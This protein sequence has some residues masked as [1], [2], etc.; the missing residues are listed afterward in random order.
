[1]LGFIDKIPLLQPKI[2]D[3]GYSMLDSGYSMLDSGYSM[4]DSG[5][6]MLDSGYS[7]LDSGYSISYPV[8]SIQ[9]LTAAGKSER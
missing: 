5:Y 2:L 3:T 9:N 1:M 4:L 6:S 8:S 7:M